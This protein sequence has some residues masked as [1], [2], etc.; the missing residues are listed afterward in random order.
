MIDQNYRC[1]ARACRLSKDA[2][3][4][5]PYIDSNVKH[6]G[7]SKLRHLDAE[8][9]SA[10]K[11]TLVLQSGEKPLAVLI[12]YETYIAMQS[13]IESAGTF[14]NFST[15]RGKSMPY[16]FDENLEASDG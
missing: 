1:L 10:L 4:H 5:T 13:L 6:V 11:E 16:D 15:D 12:P 9:L 7:V 3:K 8:D 14:L 2:R